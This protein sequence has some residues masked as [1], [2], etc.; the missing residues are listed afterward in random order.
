MKIVFAH[1]VSLSFVGGGEKFLINVSRLLKKRGYDVEIR[2]LPIHR[3]KKG[4]PIPKEIRYK[5]SSF[6]RFDADVTYFIYIPVLWRAFKTSSPKIAGIH[7]PPLAPDLLS[8]EVLPKRLAQF[9]RLNG[10]EFAAPYLY[11]KKFGRRE[12]KNFDAV[13]LVNPS[14]NIPHRAVYKIPNFV[15][16]SFFKPCAEKSEKF[17]VLF[18][19]RI[20]WR[21]GFDL[22]LGVAKRFRKFGDIEFVTTGRVRSNLVRSLGYVDEEDMPR[23]YSS[24]H[25]T[26]YPSRVDT[27]GLVILESLACGTP[28]LT[29]PIRAHTALG[30]PLLYGSSVGELAKNVKAVYT[31]WE[32]GEYWSLF[33]KVRE[34]VVENYDVGKVLPKFEMMLKSVAAG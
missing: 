26:L 34:A 28:V 17:T 22:F 2:S 12:L 11:F 32:K 24:A 3:R 30:L 6:H 25:L 19:G 23:L 27:L 21:K 8:P 7:A 4:Y 5:E 29:T 10:V 20:S 14:M 18:V 31:S 9:L 33:G 15:D 13:H 1:H 16:T